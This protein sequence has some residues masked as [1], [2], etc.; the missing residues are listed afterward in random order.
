MYTYRHDDVFSRINF[1]FAA[2][3]FMFIGQ[4]NAYNN[5]YRRTFARIFFSVL[6]RRVRRGETSS[7][8]ARR[9]RPFTFTSPPYA[10]PASRRYFIVF[11]EEVFIRF[12]FS[13]FFFL[14]LKTFYRPSPFYFRAKRF[15]INKVPYFSLRTGPALLRGRADLTV[16]SADS[17]DR[18]SI[19]IYRCGDYARFI[20]KR[21]S[22]S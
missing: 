1:C 2:V 10:G 4:R 8:T 17:V 9:V 12:D 13:F 16:S 6:L 11:T 22:F 3:G 5:T 15:S 19:G 20:R 7:W 21:G 14:L 18:I